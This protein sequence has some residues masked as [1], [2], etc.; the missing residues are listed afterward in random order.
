MFMLKSFERTAEKAQDLHPVEVMKQSVPVVKAVKV[1]GLSKFNKIVPNPISRRFSRQLLVVSKHSPTLLFAGGVVGVVATT[2]MACRATLKLEDVLEETNQNFEKAKMLLASKNANY[3][4]GDYQKD[5]ALLYVRGA[6]SVGKLY[7]PAILVGAVSIGALAGSHNILSKRNASLTVA[8]AAIEK[9]FAQYRARVTEEL[10]A[11]KDRE[12]RYGSENHTIVVDNKKKGEGFQKTKVVKRVG[13]D[14]PSVYARFFDEYSTYWS[15]E[16]EYNHVFIN[17]QQN[18]ANDMLHSR[19]HIFLNE[20]YDMLGIERSK[21]GAVVGWV[22]SRD[23][24]DNDIDFGV[25]QGV[26]Q[27]ARDFVN[28][29]EGSILLDFNVDGVIYDKI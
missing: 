12:F 6:V 17:C 19:G 1:R 21:A 11:D 18:Y 5:T 16:P 8:Y 28:G 4:H 13:G 10:G 20:V 15:R 29:R 9:G 22:I 24:G 25:F 2:V 3:S 7:T 14:D 23:D 27:V 26:N